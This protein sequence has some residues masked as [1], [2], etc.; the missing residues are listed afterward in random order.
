MERA[1]ESQLVKTG[2]RFSAASGRFAFG[3]RAAQDRPQ[4]A[5]ISEKFPDRH[6]RQ[7]SGGILS[8]F[9]RAFLGVPALAKVLK[10]PDGANYRPAVVFEWVTHAA[11]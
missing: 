6:S 2:S 8:V 11:T 1:I 5:S 10:R 4:F 3:A 7:Q 9:Q